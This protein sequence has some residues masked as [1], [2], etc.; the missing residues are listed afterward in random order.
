MSKIYL[1]K[2]NGVII[3]CF[4][5]LKTETVNVKYH[6]TD[7]WEMTFEVN[8]Y[9]DQN[10]KLVH[11]D[12]Y[13]SIVSG[14]KLYLDDEKNQ[15]YFII[16]KEP[17]IEINGDNEVK[18]VTCC[19]CECELQNIFIK[20]L[21]I[22]TGNKG[23]SAEYLADDNVD[24]YTGLPK[25]YVSLVNYENHQLSLL[26]LVLE[27]SDWTVQENIPEDI[28]KKQYS[29]VLD[30]TDIY[31][32]LTQELGFTAQ[33]LVI[34]DRKYKTIGLA[35]KD[36]IGKDTGIFL[37]YRSL[38]NQ[39]G[40]SPINENSLVTK[41][42]PLGN[43]NLG[44]F[45]ANFGQDFIV[46]LDYYM[47]AK[48]EYG[49]YKF[50]TKELSDKYNSYINDTDVE[51][52]DYDGT[53]YTR[54]ELYIELCKRYNTLQKERTEL[55]NRVPNDG[56]AIDYNTYKYDELIVS[57]KAYNNA[58]LSL[59]TLYKN[60]YD[61]EYIG[62][63]P[64][65]NPTPSDRTH[66]K[67]TVYWYD[68]AAYK[69]T[70]LPKVYEALKLWCKT[71]EAGDLCDEMGNS[72]AVINEET[73][74]PFNDGK[75]TNPQVKDGLLKV[76]DSY[77]YD[78]SLYG[79]DELN[80]KRLSWIQVVDSIYAE[81][82]IIDQDENGN[83]VY[84]TPD[85]AGWDLLGNNKKNFTNKLNYIE[86]LNI[87]LDY[88]SFDENRENGITG[89][90]GKGIIRQCEDTI[91]E[92]SNQ[93]NNIDTLMNDYDILRKEL[94]SKFSYDGYFTSEEKKELLPLINERDYT[95]ENIITTNLD[96]NVTFVQKQY[97]L[98]KDAKEKLYVESHPQWHFEIQSDNFLCI[99]ELNNL[100]SDFQ[101]G[102][103]IRVQTNLYKDEF[104]KLRL[105][106]IQTNPCEI[107]EKLNME[108][109]DV[110]Y[111]Y[112]KADDFD[113]IFS[114][115]YNGSS[116]SSSSSSGNSS[117]SSSGGGN[118]GDNDADIQISNNILNALLSSD[119]FGT[120]VTDVVL[121]GIVA[122][123]GNFQNMLVGS[124]MANSVT[125]GKTTISGNCLTTGNIKSTNYSENEKVGS[126]F[127]LDNGTFESYSS[128]GNYIKNNG[129]KI[130]IKTD[131]FSID[132]NGNA[133][134]SGDIS[135]ATGTF[136]GKISAETGI[137]GGFEVG[138]YNLIGT[139]VGMSSLTGHGWAFWAGSNDGSNA[140]FKVGHAGELY[141]T[142]ATITGTISG[143]TITGG[144]IS[145][146]TITGGSLNIGNGNFVVDSSG[147][148]T[149]KNTT[150]NGDIIANG[151]IYIYSSYSNQYYE[152]VRW[153]Y[154]T[155]T[156]RLV[157]SSK[158]DGSD[159]DSGEIVLSNNGDGEYGGCV[160]VKGNLILKNVNTTSST[161]G[162][163]QL[164]FNPKNNCLYVKS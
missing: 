149:I 30:N 110:T 161:T 160:I 142:K 57:L 103:Y 83:P 145:G 50:T 18:T 87:Y 56:C 31:S 102:N 156:N 51:K 61:V 19:S 48:D 6:L 20:S 80:A 68:F 140:P 130:E 63:F 155:E 113:Y 119:K 45:Y 118:Y 158:L 74:V 60:E 14:M 92:I 153:E 44:I 17:T 101:L 162:M 123:K 133:K 34:F 134:F 23:I 115:L 26:H 128:T 135:G 126:I 36:D 27:K 4:N 147:N 111:T 105:I 62:D 37:S 8:K 81:G 41:Y 28:Q 109:S 91:N 55:I 72:L 154:S 32:F 58:I 159:T 144:T 25:Q 38:L 146:T 129:N 53:E 163:K 9:V 71:N 99:E 116:S 78:F 59:I 2:P 96:D 49:N 24:A 157:I 108:F 70:I 29:F 16:N 77:L 69:E 97:E 35:E 75:T 139:N 42:Y 82:F 90:N 89:K 3:G 76:I 127:D 84:N 112:N 100:V 107:T 138:K 67:D 85:D 65:Y 11:S 143:S 151:G 122:N 22:N 13:E 152:A 124:I 117:S 7:I 93:I 150:I 114:K 132:E 106:S 12:Y 40:K 73:L 47:N 21:E 10:G 1:A 39:L 141:A 104:V 43:D 120:A 5:G 125:V 52:V 137:I 46:D 131:N 15:S 95:N 86:K 33:C 98:Y 66:I 121:D 88:M 136:N 164:Y 54:R 94:S 79:L 148:S 64:D